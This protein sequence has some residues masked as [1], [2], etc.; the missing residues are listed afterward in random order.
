MYNIV[1]ALIIRGY[2]IENLC[3]YKSNPQIENVW[4]NKWI[5]GH[6]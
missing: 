2:I 1:D 3:E 6:I 4:V 5:K